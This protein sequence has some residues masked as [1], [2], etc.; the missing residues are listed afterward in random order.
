M[1][2]DKMFGICENK[3]LV[4]VAPKTETDATKVKVDTKVSKDGNVAETVTGVKTF[5]SQINISKSGMSMISMKNSLANVTNFDAW[6]KYMNISFIGT[7]G[8]N[9]VAMGNYIISTD[10]DKNPRTVIQSTRQVD[11]VTKTG[12]ITLVVD[13][14]GI[15]YATAPTPSSATDNSIKIATTKWIND[16]N[17][18]VVHKSRAEIINGAKTFTS[19]LNVQGGYTIAN[20]FNKNKNITS[21]GA[22]ETIHAMC[23][24]GTDGTDDVQTGSYI[25]ST[26]GSG[27]PRTVIQT[28][29]LVDGVSKIGELTLVVKSDGNSFATAPTPP[30]TAT[31][32]EI[33]TAGW[34][35]DRRKV[36]SYAN[37]STLYESI[38]NMAIGDELIFD[39]ISF[40]ASSDDSDIV[41]LNYGS[42][43]KT[44]SNSLIGSCDI[45][46]GTVATG[47]EKG[48]CFDII[49]NNDQFSLL[50]RFVYEGLWGSGSKNIALSRLDTDTGGRDIIFINYT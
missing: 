35:R 6:A 12:E 33:A 27:N 46:V 30:S 23:F 18:D 31:S 50:Y 45:Q 32:N 48:V 17:N 25:I 34:V 10:G 39:N 1:A 41:I 42:F 47:H 40:D 38:R 26:D 29:R 7:D 15:P 43:K 20:F 24:Y 5:T 37:A 9:D 21:M 16:I 14:G 13:S 19:P 3:C 36:V 49:A 22:W 11:D 2:H 28:R 44:S 4:E 8:T